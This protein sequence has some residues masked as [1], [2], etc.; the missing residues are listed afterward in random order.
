MSTFLIFL[1]SL[2]LLSTLGYFWIRLAVKISGWDDLTEQ[3]L[4]PAP[5][6]GAAWH[7]Q[8][9]HFS[10]GLQLWRSVTVAVNEYGLY[11]EPQFPYAHVAPP[12]CIPWHDLTGSRKGTLRVE[13]RPTIRIRIN[14]ALLHQIRIV[15]AEYQVPSS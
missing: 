9:L 3:Y 2:L 1:S 7:R 5:F 15:Q 10:F 12:V 8:T 13:T 6:S 14:P 11:L 4:W